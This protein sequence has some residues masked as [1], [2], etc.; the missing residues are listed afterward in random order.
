MPLPPSGFPSLT[1][2][3]STSGSSIHFFYD[4]TPSSSSSVDALRLAALSSGLKILPL[5]F[6]PSLGYSRDRFPFCELE[7]WKDE[8]DSDVRSHQRMSS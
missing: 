2:P 4:S 3:I 7:N 1:L 8:N 5:S 6:H